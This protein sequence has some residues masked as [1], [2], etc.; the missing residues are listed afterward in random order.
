MNIQ[1]EAARRYPYA[2]GGEKPT[3]IDDF[4]QD[5]FRDVFAKGAEWARREETPES[6]GSSRFGAEFDRWL[7]AHDQEVAAQ[8]WD[9][10]YRSAYRGQQIAI[11]PENP[12]RPHT[13]G[14]E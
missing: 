6:A 13:I 9:E 8:A 4:M 3:I 14:G 12:Y 2:Y 11:V 1:E 7:A 5:I 10:G